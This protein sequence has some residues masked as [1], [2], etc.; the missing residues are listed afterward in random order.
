[1]S[2]GGLDVNDKYSNRLTRAMISDSLSVDV[3]LNVPR[4]ARIRRERRRVAVVSAFNVKMRALNCRER[5]IRSLSVHHCIA[6]VVRRNDR[7]VSRS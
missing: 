2:A 1:M 3:V 5:E 6:N 4:F 7:P